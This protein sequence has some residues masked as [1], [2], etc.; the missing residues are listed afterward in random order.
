MCPDARTSRQFIER[1]RFPRGF[2]CSH[3]GEKDEPW[4]SGTGLLACVT[5]R[6]PTPLTAG[7]LFEGSPVS[8]QRWL[9]LLWEA[10][11][12]EGGLSVASAQR[13]LRLHD[14]DSAT[15]VLERIRHMMAACSQAMLSRSVQVGITRLALAG[16]GVGSGVGSGRPVIAMAL[17]TE[18][19]GK[20]RVRLRALGAV[21]SR[22]VARFVIDHVEEGSRVCTNPWRGFKAIGSAGYLHHVTGDS[23]TALDGEIARLSSLL[24][25]WLWSSA[26][27]SADN[28]QACLH[29][30][31]FRYNRR[32]YPKGLLFYRLLILAVTVDQRELS[33]LSDVG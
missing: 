11:D 27:V 1:L 17:G 31:S 5:C 29:D 4:R 12:H 32:E 26:D 14:T 2:V 9:R 6:H 10:A 28:L 16:G 19:L 25:L 20:Q 33:R 13:E 22:E 8:L 24:E 18:G 21:S 7:T 30:F 23:A 15:R 3:C